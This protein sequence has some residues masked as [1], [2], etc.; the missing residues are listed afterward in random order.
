MLIA[1]GE[2]VLCSVEEQGASARV[3]LD[4]E[5]A[6]GNLARAPD[7]PILFAN[8]LDRARREVPGP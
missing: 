3:W 1:A 4:L 6:V 7:W 5:P 8:L 2:H